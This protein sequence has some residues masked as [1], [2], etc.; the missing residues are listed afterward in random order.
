MKFKRDMSEYAAGLRGWLL[1]MSRYQKRAILVGLDVVLVS[2]ALWL[3]LAFRLGTSYVPDQSATVALLIAAPLIV[4]ATLWWFGVYRLVTRYTGPRGL[5]QIWMS[6]GLAT[7]I[8]SLVVFLSG[9]N[10]IPRTII[11]PF[12]FGAAALLSF[13]RHAIKAALDVT[14]DRPLPMAPKVPPKPAVIYGASRMGIELLASVERAREHAVVGF[15]DNSP[16]LW[17]QYIHG[18]KV[19]APTHLPRLVELDGICEVLVAIPNLRERRE[20]LRELERLPVAVKVLPGYE[21]IASAMFGAKDLRDVEVGD[22]LGRDPVAPNPLLMMRTT[23]G[24]SILVT[25]AGGSIGSELVRQVASLGPRRI[26]LFDVSEPALYKVELEV[27]EALANQPASSPRPRIVSV[28]GSV[29]DAKLVRDTIVENG[30]ETIFHAAAYKHVP[31]VEHNPVVGLDNN[32]FGTRVVAECARD[33]GVERFVLVST[34]K[35]VR[36]TNTMGASKRVAEL[37]LQAMA[38]EQPQTVYTVVRFGNVLDS[39]GSVVP[40]FRQQI[41]A[42]GPVTVTHPDVTRYFMSIPEAASLVIQAGA[43]AKGGDV[44]VLQMGEPIRIDDLAR[45]MIRLSNRDVR[46]ETNP[47]GDIEIVYSGLRAGEKLNEELLIGAQTAPT[48]HARIFK[49]DEPFVPILTLEAEL[50]ALRAT[51]ALRD[52]AAMRA[53]L[54]RMVEGYRPA[55]QATVVERALGPDPVWDESVP[56]TLH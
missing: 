25:G 55:V 52:L 3:S 11:I 14:E 48:E 1:G 38:A 12:G 32:V 21:G 2:L 8:W 33:A 13:A 22:L 51:M 37:I 29:L 46:D 19:F 30:I 16:T 4:G 10:A 23:R 45:L 6:V 56:K 44:F 17:R 49:S 28:L 36:P 15:I 47:N 18:V 7:L 53:I 54:M 27:M 41:G 31:L 39:S 35:A 26:V 24:K 40:R 50:E 43:M 34:D 42:G 5:R 20:V 9:Q